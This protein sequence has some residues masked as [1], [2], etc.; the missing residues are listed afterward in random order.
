MFNLIKKIRFLI[1]IFFIS[2]TFHLMSEVQKDV[3]LN[4]EI[5]DAHPIFKRF[6]TENNDISITKMIQFIDDFQS[7]KLIEE[8]SNKELY[9]AVKFLNLVAKGMVSQEPNNNEMQDFQKEMEEM[10]FFL[11]DEDCKF[12]HIK[13]N[14]LE[15]CNE[16]KGS[17][18]FVT[19]EVKDIYFYDDMQIIKETSL[20]VI[21]KIMESDFI[22]VG[23][24]NNN[25]EF[26]SWDLSI[27]ETIIKIENDWDNLNTFLKPSEMAVFQI[28]EKGLQELENLAD[29][30]EDEEN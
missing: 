8:S 29:E 4:S 5:F 17:L 27:E 22:I 24:L 30:D 12:E 10:L 3:N 20:M 23:G 13:E 11:E 25:N 19:E 21:K 1:F 6:L 26:I 15:A 9:E 7:G 14:I 18:Y 16:N 28:T 2:V